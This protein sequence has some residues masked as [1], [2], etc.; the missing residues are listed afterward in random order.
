MGGKEERGEVDIEGWGCGEGGNFGL[1]EHSNIS[2]SIKSE[3]T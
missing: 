1:S 3:I 2:L